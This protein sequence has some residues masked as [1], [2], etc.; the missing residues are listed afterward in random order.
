M[1]SWVPNTREAIVNGN[2]V[3]MPP[4]FL[5]TWHSQVM[6]ATVEQAH[7]YRY[8]ACA[9]NEP[10]KGAW[11]RFRIGR[12][13]LEYGAHVIDTTSYLTGKIQ[14]RPEPKFHTSRLSKGW[15]N[16]EDLIAEAKLEGDLLWVDTPASFYPQGLT[17]V[18][19][20]ARKDYEAY[21]I[22][23]D[24]AQPESDRKR[25]LWVGPDDKGGKSLFDYPP[26]K[27]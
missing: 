10:D 27:V 9:S 12:H 17:V 25:A 3:L 13:E 5:R 4:F 7:Q 8:L 1:E 6:F 18:E 15:V 11:D 21:M 14:M 2:K 19:L 23:A 22:K 16:L 20:W 26:F 24:A